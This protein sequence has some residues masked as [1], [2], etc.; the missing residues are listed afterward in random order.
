MDIRIFKE[1]V[2]LVRALCEA[3]GNALAERLNNAST[4]GLVVAGGRSVRAFLRELSTIPA[5]WGRVNVTLSDERWI[6]P[7]SADSN[8]HQLRH[9]FHREC[10]AEAVIIG[11][12][13]SGPTPRDGL[14]EAER[15]L[16]DFPF[17]ATATVLGFGDD[18]HVASLFSGNEHSQGLLIDSYSPVFPMPRISMSMATLSNTSHLFILAP[19]ILKGSFIKEVLTEDVD[20]P[21]ARLIYMTNRVSIFLVSD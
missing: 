7:D 8:E 11:L 1:E 5:Q 13:T 18:G 10:A 6:A 14:A 19:T 12:K 2:D 9:L 16:H 15:R 21:I 3:V 17:P 20:C 4:A